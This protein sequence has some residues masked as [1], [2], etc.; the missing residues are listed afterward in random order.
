M[1]FVSMMIFPRALCTC[2]SWLPSLTKC[3]RNCVSS[4]SRFLKRPATRCF[5]SKKIISKHS[6]HLTRRSKSQHLTENNHHSQQGIQSYLFSH[7]STNGS[8]GRRERTDKM[9]PLMKSS[10]QSSSKSWPTTRGALL[11]FTC[12]EDK[13]P[14]WSG[15]LW[16][17]AAVHCNTRQATK[18]GNRRRPKLGAEPSPSGRILRCTEACCSNTDSE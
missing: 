1:W 11:G 5:Q 6:R 13:N 14:P 17:K 4:R 18:R 16:K 2:T 3:S 7:S 15:F 12:N 8:T 9:R 10:G